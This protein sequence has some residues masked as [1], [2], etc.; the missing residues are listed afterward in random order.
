MS[1]TWHWYT[2]GLRGW[3]RDGCGCALLSQAQGLDSAEGSG[4]PDSAE[5][6]LKPCLSDVECSLQEHLPEGSGQSG[7]VG[8][9]S[10]GFG[11]LPQA[12]LAYLSLVTHP[13]LLPSPGTLTLC[14]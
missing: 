1:S 7:A 10:M 5:P 11:A 8:Y 14:R 2:G 3:D 13:W 4:G 12:G 6:P 9:K